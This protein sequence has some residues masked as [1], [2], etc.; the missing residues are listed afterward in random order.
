MR[1]I[2][3]IFVAATIFYNYYCYIVH[4]NVIIIIV[5]LLLLLLLLLFLLLLKQFAPLAISFCLSPC[6]MWPIYLYQNA[7]KARKAQK[8]HT[9]LSAIWSNPNHHYPYTIHKHILQQFLLL[10]LLLLL[11]FFL[12]LL[13]SVFCITICYLCYRTWTTFHVWSMPQPRL[14]LPTSIFHL[15]CWYSFHFWSSISVYSQLNSRCR[16]YSALYDFQ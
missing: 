7:Q 12:L 15:Y 16:R 2:I 6:I 5:Q 1:N 13:V 4:T 11:L 14:A 9:Q 3:I 10:L 8:A